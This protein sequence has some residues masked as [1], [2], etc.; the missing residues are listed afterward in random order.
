MIFK[1]QSE[2]NVC[3]HTMKHEH[4]MEFDNDSNVFGRV[5]AY[6]EYMKKT[7]PECEYRLIKARQV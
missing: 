1:V 5:L 6:R 7:F 4:T 2:V 3:G